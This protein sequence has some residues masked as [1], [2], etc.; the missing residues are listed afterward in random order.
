VDDEAFLP[1][2]ASNYM[3]GTLSGQGIWSGLRCITTWTV[4]T[5]K[6]ES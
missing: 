4:E 5:A 2:A 1:L 6:P 3:L